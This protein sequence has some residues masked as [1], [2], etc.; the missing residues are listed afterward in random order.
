MINARAR[1]DS[2]SRKLC[3]KMKSDQGS[4]ST[5]GSQEEGDTEEGRNTRHGEGEREGQELGKEVRE[6]RFGEA[7]R[8]NDEHRN[9]LQGRAARGLGRTARAALIFQLE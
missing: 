9:R 7:Q 8:Q 5:Y 4:L 3:G 6:A 2:F 1:C